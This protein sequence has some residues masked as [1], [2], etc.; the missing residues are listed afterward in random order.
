MEKA[1]SSSLGRFFKGAIASATSSTLMFGIMAGVQATIGAF[2]GAQFAIVPFLG[3]ALPVIAAI[4]IFGGVMAVMKGDKHHASAT[5]RTNEA[6]QAVLI[7]NGR[8]L[9][10]TIAP[11]GPVA[12][13][14]LDAPEAKPRW[15]DRP[16]IAQRE[17]ASIAQILSNGQ[18]P[19]DHAASILAAQ[20]TGNAASR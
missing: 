13:D 3:Y 11:T 16:D 9:A 19:K 2:S 20:Q 1:Q 10:P 14:E 8:G 12:A 6:S 5:A 4:A 17:R 7:A 18:S 15:T